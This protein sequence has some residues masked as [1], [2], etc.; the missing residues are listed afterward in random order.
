MLYLLP[1]LRADAIDVGGMTMLKGKSF[2][3]CVSKERCVEIL[4]EEI[5]DLLPPEKR[6]DYERSVD[7]VLY[8]FKKLDG[9]KPKYNKGKHINDWYTCRHCGGSVDVGHNYCANCGYQ[10]LWDGTRCMTDRKENRAK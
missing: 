1:G 10:L 4:T 3:A 2:G 7:R 9:A 8:E 5:Q 6:E